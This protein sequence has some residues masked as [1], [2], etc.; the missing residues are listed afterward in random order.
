MSDQELI[1]ALRCT[2]HPG[3]PVGD[4]KKCP[5]LR[6]EHIG[7]DL[8]KM[9]GKDEWESCDVDGVAIAAADRIANQ[10]THILAL[11]KEIEKLR[12][13]LPRWIPVEERLPEERVLVNVV[14][15][16]RAPEPYYEKIKG[17]PVS[18][19][20][21]FYGGRWYW[22]SPVLLDYLAEYGED[23]FDLIDEA[24]E[25]THWMPLPEPPE[26]EGM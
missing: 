7:P 23:E 21:C 17:V 5:F 14:W 6:T 20:A 12:G 11:Q 2:A 4:C 9:A 16:N 3:G 1:D 22:D 26:K 13:Q 19:T 24:V 18:D 8:A 15:V 10:N 25:I